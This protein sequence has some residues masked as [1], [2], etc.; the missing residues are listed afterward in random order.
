MDNLTHSLIGCALAELV[1]QRTPAA[2]KTHPSPFLRGLFWVVSIVGN[3]FPDLDVLYAPFAIRGG[4]LGYLLHH[5]G[6]THTLLLAI[7]QGLLIGGAAQW[8]ISRKRKKVEEPERKALWLLAVLGPLMH[9][10]MDSANNYGVHPFWPVWNGW[11]FGDSLFI[12][13]PLLWVALFPIPYFASN[14]R[15]YRWVGETFLIALFTAMWILPLTRW[16]S[17][18]LILAFGAL[19]WHFCRRSK[20]R[21][22]ADFC[23]A[24][25]VMVVLVFS[26]CSLFSR[27]IIQKQNAELHPTAALQDVVLTPFPANPLCWNLITV[28]TFSDGARYRVRRGRFALAPSLVAAADCP[29]FPVN[30]STAFLSPIPALWGPQYDWEGQY[31]TAVS[32]LK[33]YEDYSCNW[34]NFLGFAR[35]P[36]LQEEGEKIWAGDLR[37]DYGPE[38]GFAELEVPEQTSPC[39][40]WIPAWL[41]PRRALFD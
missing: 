31:Q 39:L 33:G 19:L 6:H 10:A 29:R 32:D 25:A 26:V 34:A 40:G 9:I 22:R 13:E 11:V 17:A 20:P 37:F 28:E 30:G 41:K 15:T 24:M 4:S 38:L 7:A 14:R 21:W 16:Y 1:F 3:N 2:A 35:V 36:F 8:W 18:V 27:A 23:S 5:R 12:M